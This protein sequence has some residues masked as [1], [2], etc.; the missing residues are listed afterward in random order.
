MG[1]TK[2]SYADNYEKIFGK[3][4]VERGRFRQD[5]E[6]GKFIPI[7]EWLKKYGHST[8]KGPIIFCNHFTPFTSPIDGKVIESKRQHQYD[9]DK[10]GC[11][12]YEGF[13]S[14][15]KEADRYLE[16]KEKDLE[17]NVEETLNQTMHDIESGYLQVEE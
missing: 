9:L 15:K 17:E 3:T 5:R 6:T 1:V 2:V 10:N 14:E 8:P 13:E 7:S 12:V 11:R 16:Y 4:T